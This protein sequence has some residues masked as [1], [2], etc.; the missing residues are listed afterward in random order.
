MSESNV[1][2][3]QEGY[4]AIGETLFG[5]AFSNPRFQAQYKQSFSAILGMYALMELA[6]DDIPMDEKRPFLRWFDEEMHKNPNILKGVHG[7]DPS[8][9]KALIGIFNNMSD[10]ENAYITRLVSSTEGQQA[11]QSIREGR[12][13]D[14]INWQGRKLEKDILDGKIDQASALGADFTFDSQDAVWDQLDLLKFL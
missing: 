6:N 4:N 8:I 7:Q 14:S 9:A 1:I 2:G 10:P 3:W 13:K 12:V 11:G 5:P